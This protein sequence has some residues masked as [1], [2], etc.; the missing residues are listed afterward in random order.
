MSIFKETLPKFIIDQLTIREA[1]V[2]MGNNVTPDGAGNIPSPRTASPRVTLKG[3]EKKITIDS[4]AFFTNAISKQCV[5]RMSS[6]VDVKPGTFPQFPDEPTGIELAQRF[7]LEGGIPTEDL[8]KVKDEDNNIREVRVPRGGF[9]R[10]KG[11]AYGDSRIRSSARDGFGIVPMPG[12]IDANIRTKTAYGSLRDAKINFVCHNRDQLEILELLYMRPGYPVLLEWGWL[13]YIN[14]DGRRENFFP[15]MKE[16]WEKGT[17]MDQVNEKIIKQKE[18]SGGNYDAMNGIVKNFEIK[19]RADGGYDC[20]CELISMGEV[21]EGLKGKAGEDNDIGY[22]TRKEGTPMSTFL[23]YLAVLEQIATGEGVPKN[24]LPA[25][26]R[27]IEE[28]IVPKQEDKSEEAKTQ[29]ASETNPVAADL[30]EA[31]PGPPDGIDTEKKLKAEQATADNKITLEE[32]YSLNFTQKKEVA[33]IF[34]TDV[35]D[36]FNK[37]SEDLQNGGDGLKLPPPNESAAPETPPPLFVNK[38]TGEPFE[39]I[40]LGALAEESAAGF[41]SGRPESTTGGLDRSTNQAGTQGGYDQDVQIEKTKQELEFEA[42]RP[43]TTTTKG[44]DV[45]K[46]F[47]PFIVRKSDDLFPNTPG[48]SGTTFGGGNFM[49]VT[50]DLIIEIFNHFIV[51]MI[52]E[53]VT[54]PGKVKEIL[55]DEG[56]NVNIKKRE[57]EPLVRYTYYEKNTNKYLTYSKITFPTGFKAGVK[58]IST[59]GETLDIDSGVL[60]GSSLDK[61]VCLL[62]H[63]FGRSNRYL[64]APKITEGLLGVSEAQISEYSIGKTC[65]NINYLIQT[66]LSMFYDKEGVT[67]EFNFL[68]YFKK[69]WEQDVNNACAD[70]HNFVINV[71]PDRNN[72]IRVIDYDIQTLD[73]KTPVKIDSKGNKTPAQFSGIRAEDVYEFKVQS[74]ESIV[75]DFNFNTSIPANMASIISIAAGAPNDVSALDEVSFAAFNKDITS[76]FTVIEDTR[77]TADFKKE[78]DK[79][80]ND[81]RKN[82]KTLLQYFREM[83]LDSSFEGDGESDGPSLY[84]AKD[85]VSRMD[86]L[87]FNVT[88]RDYTG[89][90]P[91]Y[92][93]D[94]VTNPSKSAVIPL[95]FNAKMDGIAGMVI[96]NVF[97]VDKTRL[98]VGYQRKDIAFIITTE[99]QSITAGQDWTTDITGQLMLLDLEKE[100]IELDGEAV[101]PIQIRLI[102][103]DDRQLEV[104]NDLNITPGVKELFTE[105]IIEVQETTPY[106][107]QL[108]SGYRDFTDQLNKRERWDAGNRTGLAVKPAAPGRS[109]HQYGLAIDMNPVHEDGTT[110]MAKDSDDIWEATGI[111]DIADRLGLRWGGRFSNRDAIHFDLPKV[112]GYVH[113][114]MRDSL[115]PFVL[116]QIGEFHLVG[117][118]EDSD[119]KLRGPFKRAMKKAQG[120][121]IDFTKFDKDKLALAILNNMA[122]E[123][124]ERH[125][126]L[127]QNAT[128]SG[129]NSRTYGGTISDER[130]KTNII[131]VG[132]TEYGIP[133]Y[134]FNYKNVLG[135]DHTS[136]FRGIMAQDLLKTNMSK[137]VILNNNSYYSIDYSQLNINLEKIS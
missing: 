60:L 7:V 6:G 66:Y 22:R 50:W 116:S 128:Y 72:R 112:G 48:V 107:V 40:D 81:L 16:W 41:A 55:N 132:N 15:Y 28:V 89:E 109:L 101:P 71:P 25:I 11:S 74:N 10:G 14:N 54:S 35:D 17:T 114:D 2:K 103:L 29:E 100:R 75:R 69:I 90:N 30:G 9:A 98:P 82:M 136:R 64:P 46:I 125:D 104:I 97:K 12:I 127:N 19:S 77:T 8:I 96:G 5:L 45:D 31:P 32:W 113:P 68:D 110:I 94:K 58:D 59:F 118:V 13:P 37:I 65:F 102:E 115:I 20:S 123:E 105:F 51:P 38:L 21:L 78:F 99:Q 23:Y 42:N 95:R 43:V 87:I 53:N 117:R 39:E 92:R 120:N 57:P 26:E 61:S 83:Y 52:K 1:I 86:S 129:A 133:L 49:G 62:P 4:S 70:Q 44:Y 84:S 88:S 34:S 119:G 121:Q 24:F 108:N 106:Y 56:K 93:R 67:D 85:I 135:L 122:I 80:V 63:Q 47:A 27:I 33:K 130:L 111:I 137:A 73:V 18:Q 76:R 126:G 134:E 124:E 3:S 79:E 131:K 91:T 36:L